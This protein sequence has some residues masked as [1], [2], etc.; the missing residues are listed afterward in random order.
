MSYVQ[1]L[2]ENIAVGAAMGYGR[3]TGKPGV[4]VL[5]V[6]PGVGHAINW[7][8]SMRGRPGS[9]SLSSEG[10]ST[11]SFRFK[12]RSCGPTPLN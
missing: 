7:C 12:S 11:Q 6:T 9:R 2:H 5:H 1:V 10:S 4:C 8:R 3:T